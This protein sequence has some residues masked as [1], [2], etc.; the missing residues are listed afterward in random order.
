MQEQEYLDEEGQEYLD[1][2]GL[3]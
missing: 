1:E 3:K 2:E